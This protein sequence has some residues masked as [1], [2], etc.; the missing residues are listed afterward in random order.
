M[1]TNLKL[2]ERLLSEACKLS[3]L[4]TKKDTVEEALR[5]LIRNRKL[6]GLYK[7]FGTVDF[8]PDYDYKEQRKRAQ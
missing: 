5:L 6:A 8:D 2:D 7:M 4:K 1:A 3:G